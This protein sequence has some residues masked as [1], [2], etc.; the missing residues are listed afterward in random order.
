MGLP[1][2]CN[3][4]GNQWVHL[5]YSMFLV[6][7]QCLYFWFLW[8]D[9]PPTLSALFFLFV[10]VFLIRMSVGGAGSVVSQIA[11]INTPL[12][13]SYQNIS[14]RSWERRQPNGWDKYT[15]SPFIEE[16]LSIQTHCLILVVSFLWFG[17]ASF[18]TPHYH[19]MQP[20]TY[21]DY[22]HTHHCLL[23]YRLPK[24]INISLLFLISM[25]SP[26]CYRLWVGSWQVGAHPGSWR[27]DVWEKTWSWMNSFRIRRHSHK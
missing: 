25:L 17:L 13:H 23:V 7:W 3:L 24:L 18:N 15:S 4:E 11:G 1:A 9:A 8:C 22:T 20:L 21:T 2:L 6:G 27:Y 26:F 16:T 10:L 19:I 14:G 5:L 12:P